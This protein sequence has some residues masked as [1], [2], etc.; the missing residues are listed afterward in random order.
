MARG[1]GALV[2]WASGLPAAATAAPILH[3]QLQTAPVRGRL[4]QA[5]PPPRSPAPAGEGAPPVP[6]RRGSP[7]PEGTPQHTHARAHTD[8][9]A[10]ARPGPPP[11]GPTEPRVHQGPGEGRCRVSEEPLTLKSRGRGEP[12]GPGAQ[13]QPAAAASQRVPGS[14]SG[15]GAAGA[16]R[17]AGRGARERSR[18]ARGWRCPRCRR[19][20]AGNGCR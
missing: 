20:T 15:G 7:T 4:S 13:S 14:A 1:Q 6:G 5:G 19:G 17:V 11:G 2:R 16:T 10:H 8:T 3:K 9:R 12:P 18:G